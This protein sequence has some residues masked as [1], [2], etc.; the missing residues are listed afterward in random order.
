MK[1]KKYRRNAHIY[2]NKS[3]FLTKIN[4]LNACEGHSF[5][6]ILK[7]ASIPLSVDK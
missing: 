5:K 6:M 3:K 2:I 4:A 7:K 1:H